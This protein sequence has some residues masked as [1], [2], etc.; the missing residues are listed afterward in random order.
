MAL[1]LA[2][3]L[4]AGAA[5]CG[6]KKGRP[7]E[8]PTDQPPNPNTP[9]NAMLLFQWALQHRDTAQYRSLF[10]ADYVFEFMVGDTAATNHFG[11]TWGYGEE[12]TSARH[13]L[14]EGS[15]GG[16]PAATLTIPFSMTLDDE[17]DPRPGKNPA[18]HRVVTAWFVLTIQKQDTTAD[19]IHGGGNFYLVRGDSA[20]LPTDLAGLGT[21]GRWFIER[22]EDIT[23]GV[24]PPLAL[25]PGGAGPARPAPTSLPTWGQIKV[26]YLPA[27][28]PARQQ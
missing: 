12:R 16:S 28:P 6:G 24:E 22:W 26:R 9:V 15:T 20:S 7:T 19:Q 25:R 3:A 13:L 4:A 23:G 5:G 1:A 10:T 2:A 11:G 8:P 21:S 18:W 27:G 14:V 17:P